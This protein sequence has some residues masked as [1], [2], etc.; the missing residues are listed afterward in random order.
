MVAQARLKADTMVLDV[1]N[2]FMSAGIHRLWKDHYI[3]KLDPRGGL[4][5]LDVAGGTGRP[6]LYD[7]WRLWR[8]ELV[9]R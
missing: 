3:K 7:I 6:I 5:C 1:M 9:N 8:T 2:D 4:K